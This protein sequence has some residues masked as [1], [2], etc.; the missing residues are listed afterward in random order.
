MT[1]LANLDMEA[2]RQHVRAR[3][4]NLDYYRRFNRQGPDR[5]DAEAELEV[6][7]AEQRRRIEPLGKRTF[8]RIGVETNHGYFYLVNATWE[9]Y[10]CG[11]YATGENG[12]LSGFCERGSTTARLFH[13]VSHTDQSGRV[14][15]FEYANL[16][17]LW[18]WGEFP[19][20]DQTS[21]G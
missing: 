12:T 4:A 11:P 7:Y 5:D 13:A 21:C 20:L 14:Q 19:V 8:D 16:R 17:R 18:T 6:A 9:P 10:T 3:E 15:T 2:L 1:T